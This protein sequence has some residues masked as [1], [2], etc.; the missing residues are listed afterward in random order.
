MKLSRNGVII[1]AIALLVI[2]RIVWH[3][4]QADS[5][6]P[7]INA[8]PA[9]VVVSPP[10]ADAYNYDRMLALIAKA[11]EARI[12]YRAH[13]AVVH[14]AAVKPLAI[15]ELKALLE[16]VYRERERFERYSKNVRVRYK[17]RIP[18]RR[19]RSLEYHLQVL[20]K[21]IMDLERILRRI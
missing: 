2:G 6:L 11:N 1:I 13:Y 10:P 21:A 12:A 8:A 4:W 9:S 18:L 3:A 15:H 5:A 19:A 7:H 20:D 14:E 16:D 17:S